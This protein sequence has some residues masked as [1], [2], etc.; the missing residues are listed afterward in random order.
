MLWFSHRLIHM[1]PFLYETLP[2]TSFVT[3]VPNNMYHTK[4]HFCSVWSAPVPLSKESAWGGM[5][6]RVLPFTCPEK[7][8]T[9]PFSLPTWPM[10][11][12][13]STPGHLPLLWLLAISGTSNWD[14]E[15]RAGG[16]G[17]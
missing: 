8:N 4:P 11:S 9:S 15:G 14:G 12:R 3:H 10:T 6:R 16:R 2:V 17:R 5:G 13:D 7:T 1:H